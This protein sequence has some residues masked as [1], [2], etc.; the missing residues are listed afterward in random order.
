VFEGIAREGHEK[1]FVP[2]ETDEFEPR[3]LTAGS[4]E[5]IQLLRRRA[6]MGVPM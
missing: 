4:W 1:S 3:F 6:G 5:K 2:V